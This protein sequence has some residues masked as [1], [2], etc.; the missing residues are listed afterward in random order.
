MFLVLAVGLASAQSNDLEI[1]NNTKTNKQICFYDADDKPLALIAFRCET[2]GPKTIIKI[3]INNVD[4]NTR[5]FEYGLIPRELYSHTGQKKIARIV[6]GERGA[7][8]TRRKTTKP[9][10]A[11]T[12]YSL[13]V[14]NKTSTEKIDFTLAFE[15]GV[16]TPS[17]SYGWWSVEKGRCI[18][19]PVTTMLK[20]DWNIPYGKAPSVYYYA[21]VNRD[22]AVVWEDEKP[23]VWEGNAWL[24]CINTKDVFKVKI[25]KNIDSANLDKYCTAMG[26]NFSKVGMRAVADPKA[27]T[28]VYYLNL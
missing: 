6:I 10:P 24:T 28:T 1:Y 5:V 25:D 27:N 19:F 20:A 8:F 26:A 15:F 21:R 11:S 16:L 7:T 18:D 17:Y 23:L 12:K 13:K 4:F 2:I 22:P 14:C 9:E 3:N